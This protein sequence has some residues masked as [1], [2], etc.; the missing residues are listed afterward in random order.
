[1]T[2]VQIYVGDQLFPDIPRPDQ[3]NPKIVELIT[4]AIAVNCAY[5]SKIMVRGFYLRSKP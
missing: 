5:T 4:S 3:I 2:V 1:M